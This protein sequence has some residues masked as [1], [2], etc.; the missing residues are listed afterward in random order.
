MAY[1]AEINSDNVVLRVVSISDSDTANGDGDEVESLGVA[2]CQNLFG[3][4][5]WKQT[6][7]NNRIRTR[8]A[9]VGYTYDAARN[10]FI[11][12]KPYNSWVLDSSTLEWEAPVTKPSDASMTKTYSWNEDT[13]S[14]VED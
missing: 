4:G 9:G 6:S 10:A 7:Y 1:F 5:T 11:R 8:F 12:P 13:T 3:G 2:F 14:W